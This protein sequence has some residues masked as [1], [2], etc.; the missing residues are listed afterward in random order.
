MDMDIEES[1]QHFNRQDTSLS[2][3]GSSNIVPVD[4]AHPFDLEAYISQYKGPQAILDRLIHIIPRCPSIAL[5]AV[6][7]ALQ[8][9]PKLRDMSMYRGLMNA[10]TQAVKNANNQLPPPNEVLPFDQKWLDETIAKN[11]S[12]KIKLEVELKTY[13][14]NMIKESIRVRL[15][16]FIQSI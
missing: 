10:Y 6:Q 9:I 8:Q 13:T 5:N 16:H 2:S 11:K 1:S 3:V 15:Y 12:E 14:S 7:I 4:D